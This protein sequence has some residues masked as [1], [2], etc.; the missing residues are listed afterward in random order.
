M[1]RLTN[2]QNQLNASTVM[3]QLTLEYTAGQPKKFNFWLS[4]F[5]SLFLLTLSAPLVAQQATQTKGTEFWAGFMENYVI[6]PGDQLYIYISS[7][8]NTTG[9]VEVPGQGWSQPFTVTAYQTTTVIVPNNVAEH[10]NNQIIDNKGVRITTADTSSVY[11][12]NFNQYTA[13]GARILPIQT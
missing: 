9:L 5:A 10:Y 3:K 6:E 13:D 2:S 12:I 4:V 8:V 7:S 11:S 1:I